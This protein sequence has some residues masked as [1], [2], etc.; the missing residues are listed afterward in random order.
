ML[1]D[2]LK[3]ELGTYR[4]A[5]SNQQRLSSYIIIKIKADKVEHAYE[6]LIINGKRSYNV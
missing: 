1:I 3:M 5:N 4:I 2:S 6:H